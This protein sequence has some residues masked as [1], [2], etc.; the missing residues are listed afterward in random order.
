MAGSLGRLVVDLLFP[1]RCVHCKQ[2]GQWLCQACLGQIRPVSPPYC[3][4][5]GSPGVAGICAR[6]RVHPPAFD[7][8]YSLAVYEEP[9]RSIIHH[10]KYKNGRWLAPLLGDVLHTGFRQLA[11]QIDAIVPVPLHPQREKERGFNQALLLAQELAR[12]EG[13]PLEVNLLRRVRY[14]RS[15]TGL[16]PAGRLAN[17]AGAFACRDGQKVI[18]RQVL[19]VDDVMT[20][21]ATMSA[22]AQALKSGGAGKVYA[23][24]LA[25]PSS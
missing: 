8:G 18:G 19:L 21:G 6:C 24:A 20:T 1:P 25:R 5:C 2:A 3:R 22:C 12:R 11:W 9:V 15:Q 7:I 10:L 23:L 13:L 17:V 16:D 14:T 4:W